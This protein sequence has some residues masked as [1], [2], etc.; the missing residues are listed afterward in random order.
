MSAISKPRKLTPEEYLAI[1]EKA[2]TKSDFYNGEM[3]A[4]AGASIEHICIR[5]NLSGELHGCLADTSCRRFSSD[6][7]IKVDLT[8]LYTYPDLVIVCGKVER[9]PLNRHT[10]TNPRVIMEVLSPSAEGYDLGVKFRHYQKI[11]SVREIVFV[12]QDEWVVQVYARQDD[13]SWILRTFSDPQGGFSLTSVPVEIPL[14]AVY[15]GV[16]ELSEE[17]T[18]A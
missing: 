14:S 12:S 13:E 1:E 9:D 6:Q 16:A 15:R 4:M 7:R 8:G 18:G 10:I 5:E 11:P 2:E 3:F 17:A